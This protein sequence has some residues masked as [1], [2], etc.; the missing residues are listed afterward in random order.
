MGN[1]GYVRLYDA[2]NILSSIITCK[3]RFLLHEYFWKKET[4]FGR[5]QI[6]NRES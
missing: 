4:F 6:V 5:R 1:G 2:G 3:R